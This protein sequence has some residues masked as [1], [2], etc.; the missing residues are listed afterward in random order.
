MAGTGEQPETGQRAG[1]PRT[2]VED[3]AT[4]RTG[5]SRAE[6]MVDHT[7]LAPRREG[8]DL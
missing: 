8:M 3:K 2:R 5:L 6:I 1:G 4:D 7:G